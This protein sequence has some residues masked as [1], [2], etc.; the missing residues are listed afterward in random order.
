MSYL[1]NAD[2]YKYNDGP[3]QQEDMLIARSGL[4]AVL[5]PNGDMVLLHG[6]QV[7]CQLG[8]TRVS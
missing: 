8:C 6:G 2:G 5:L 3:W 1:V 4:D 7:G